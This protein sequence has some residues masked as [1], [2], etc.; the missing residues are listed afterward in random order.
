MISGT[1]ECKVKNVELFLSALNTIMDNYEVESKGDTVTVYINT[2]Y[3]DDIVTV[4]ENSLVETANGEFTDDGEKSGAVGDFT[5]CKVNGKA[6][7]NAK[8]VIIIMNDLLNFHQTTYKTMWDESTPLNNVLKAAAINLLKQ[9][10]V[11]DYPENID[12]IS[13]DES[14]DERGMV[15]SIRASTLEADIWIASIEGLPLICTSETDVL[16]ADMISEGDYLGKD[17]IKALTD[18]AKEA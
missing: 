7:Y 6:V 15:F 16:A 2:K 8:M 9:E 10:G 3:T 14:N 12:S 18:K 1:L 13:F 5:Y 11:F 17:K 4:I